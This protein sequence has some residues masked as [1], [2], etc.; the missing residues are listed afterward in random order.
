MDKN[1]SEQSEENEHLLQFE[2]EVESL[3]EIILYA[4]SSDHEE[5]EVNEEVPNH[6]IR[7]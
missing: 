1:V 3:E 6:F 4:V 5:S 7:W 2:P